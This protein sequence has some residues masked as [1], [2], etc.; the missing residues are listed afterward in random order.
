MF[1]N[2]ILNWNEFADELTENREKFRNKSPNRWLKLGSQCNPSLV[3]EAHAKQHFAINK[4][5]L[6]E[7]MELTYFPLIDV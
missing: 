2:K 7:V 4:S 1:I 5:S 6:A 3:D